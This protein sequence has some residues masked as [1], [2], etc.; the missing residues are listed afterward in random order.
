MGEEEKEM[1]SSRHISVGI[2]LVMVVVFASSVFAQGTPGTPPPKQIPIFRKPDPNQKLRELQAAED[3]KKASRQ[4]ALKGEITKLVQKDIKMAKTKK[5]AEICTSP[6]IFYV[7]GRE[8]YPGDPVYIRGCGFG[9]S[10]GMVSISPL[11][12]QLE[13]DTWVDGRIVG[14]IP[15][16][17]T[18]FADPKTI[19]LKV[20]TIP[21][22][23]SDPSA[24]LTLKPN[25]EIQT[26]NITNPTI[27]TTC[28]FDQFQPGSQGSALH[29][30][31]STQQCQGV[32]T[33]IRG[34]EL[35]NNWLFQF[36]NFNV[37]CYK[38]LISVDPTKPPW[39]E[40]VSCGSHGSRA[41]PVENMNLFLGKSAIPNIQIDWTV[42]PVTQGSQANVNHLQYVF[43][44]FLLGPAGTNYQA[45]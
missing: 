1:K 41:N 40:E 39:T 24:S 36:F 30:N 2:V 16:D 43:Q 19:T 21:G 20:H 38:G 34:F 42:G 27:A 37:V 45:E 6:K 11:N 12:K 18:G 32:D 23:T 13:I 33:L 28:S 4:L 35:R 25:M 14:K 17:I 26:L 22:K 8:V 5:K 29:S 31:L 15:S 44:I 7:S 10:K 9:I 3:K